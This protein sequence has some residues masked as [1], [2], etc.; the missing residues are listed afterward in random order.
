[1]R[2]QSRF[3]TFV[4]CLLLVL[5]FF[6]GCASSK[7]AFVPASLV[8]TADAQGFAADGVRPLFD[9]LLHG[10]QPVVLFV[11]GRG[12]EPK[13]SL[14]GGTLVEGKAVSKLEEYGVKVVLFS[15]DSK[16]ESLFG[17]KVPLSHMPDASMRLSQVID[18][19]TSSIGA[20]EQAHVQHPPITLL[21][22]SMGT[23][24]VQTYA[25]D[26]HTWK[27]PGGRP[28]FTNVILSSPDADDVGHAGWVDKIAS[29]E[30]VFITVNP[31]DPTLKDSKDARVS[32]AHA[33]GLDPGN[34]LAAK[35]TYVHIDEQKHE[36][37]TKTASHPEI[38]TFFADLFQ[39]QEPNLG[40]AFAPPG[41]Q[42][43]L[44]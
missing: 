2:Y 9:R 4:L 6:A 17:R 30:P 24:V 29:V 41:H 28:L 43:R 10:T 16:A 25:Q 21:A 13:K 37:F 22:H 18:A 19:L 5:S 32:P 7:S 35:A 40:D 27:T 31:S 34:M 12:N 39:G 44:R 38:S 14:F 36:I 8:Y 3:L 15:W 26:D 33:L 11:H 1:M 23:I 42:F 20:M